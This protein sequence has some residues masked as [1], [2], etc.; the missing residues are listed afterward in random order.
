M[1]KLNFYGNTV[2]SKQ[3]Q[4]TVFKEK[5]DRYSGQPMKF[6]GLLELLLFC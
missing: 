1:K 4:M 2:L 3:R 6:E 5:A